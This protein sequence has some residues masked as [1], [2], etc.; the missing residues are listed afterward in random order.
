M[1]ESMKKEIEMVKQRDANM[2]C[3]SIR[4]GYNAI[5]LVKKSKRKGAQ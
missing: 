3:I 5:L 2:E 4:L 1:D